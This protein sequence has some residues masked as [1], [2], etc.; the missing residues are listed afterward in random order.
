MDDMRETKGPLPRPAALA[1]SAA[2]MGLIT[3]S[4]QKWSPTPLHPA[5]RRWYRRLDKPPFTP[6]DPVF[7]AAW[8]VLD[9]LFVF[10]GYRLMRAPASSERNGALA[11]WAVENL[12]IGGWSGLFFGRRALGASALTAGAMTG[13]AGA[14]LAAA[15]RTDRKAALAG[16]PLIGWLAFATLLAEEVWR[17]NR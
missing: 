17:R 7:G 4:G 15:A 6:P 8:A 9:S 2:A 3:W 5:M 10:G 13:V 12:M 16:L 14:Y 11:L 1:A